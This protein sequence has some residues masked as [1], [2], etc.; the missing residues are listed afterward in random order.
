[1]NEASLDARAARP[2]KGL[3]PPIGVADTL[4]PSVTLL[5]DTFA[6]MLLDP[7]QAGH[8]RL[9]PVPPAMLLRPTSTS[10]S[11]PAFLTSDPAPLAS[12]GKASVIDRY[13]LDNHSRALSVLHKRVD[14]MYKLVEHFRDAIHALLD[15]V[16]VTEMTSRSFQDEVRTS[17]SRLENI[18]VGTEEV[19]MRLEESIGHMEE[20]QCSVA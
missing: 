5:A 17:I 9:R 18:L 19:A 20:S 10:L 3:S 15:R 6:A 13:F 14:E 12:S 8:P 4:V 7:V 2:L 1:M 11:Y 16:K